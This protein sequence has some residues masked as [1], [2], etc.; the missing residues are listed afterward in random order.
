M[1]HMIR[2]PGFLQCDVFAYVFLAH[3]A[4]NY[5]CVDLTCNIFEDVSGRIGTE[6]TEGP[7]TN[8]IAVAQL[9]YDDPQ[10]MTPVFDR[11]TVGGLSEDRE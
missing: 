4:C 8:H 5:S 6:L 9:H 10:K 2:D 1:P 3:I 7:E 11:E